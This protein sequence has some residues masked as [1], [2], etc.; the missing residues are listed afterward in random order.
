M[1]LHLECK[2]HTALIFLFHCAQQTY[3]R[4]LYHIL[5]LLKGFGYL[6]DL[7]GDNLTRRLL[8]RI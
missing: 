1:V 8:R 3:Q 7:I 2:I 4:S 6:P 5:A